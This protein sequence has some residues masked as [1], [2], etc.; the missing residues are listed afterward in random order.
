MREWKREKKTQGKVYLIISHAGHFFFLGGQ[1]RGAGDLPSWLTTTTEREREEKSITMNP[2]NACICISL[3]SLVTKWKEWNK[4]PFGKEKKK[5]KTT[6]EN[7]HRHRVRLY[8]TLCNDERLWWCLKMMPLRL[9]RALRILLFFPLSLS[10]S[11]PLILRF[12]SRLTWWPYWLLVFFLATILFR[13]W[14]E[15]C[16]WAIQVRWTGI[17]NG[18]KNSILFGRSSLNVSTVCVF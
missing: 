6:R 16:W 13:W 2:L 15:K 10:H 17:W 14:L 4:S 8:T 3:A 9:E 18:V 5:K 1:H 11:S 7:M 12:L